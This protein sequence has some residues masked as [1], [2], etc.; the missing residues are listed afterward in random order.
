MYTEHGQ[1]WI[2]SF[3]CGYFLRL[4]SGAIIQKAIN[5]A[6]N[7]D[8]NANAGKKNQ[9]NRIDHFQQSPEKVSDN[10]LSLSPEELEAWR[11]K[12]DRMFLNAIQLSCLYT[13]V[14][15]EGRRRFL[16]LYKKH[17]KT[18]IGCRMSE[19]DFMRLSAPD[20]EKKIYHM[21]MVSTENTYVNGSVRI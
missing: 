15:E 4:A 18:K 19:I 5:M 13:F 3:G 20:A 11:R 14:N 8:H 7:P 10:P 6:W 12:R 21:E 1:W 2:F 9:N 17:R 16:E